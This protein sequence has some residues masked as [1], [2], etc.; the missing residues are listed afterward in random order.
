MT[1]QPPDWWYEPYIGDW[2]E[3]ALITVEQ[4]CKSCKKTTWPPPP[5]VR[6]STCGV[7]GT[8]IFEQECPYGDWWIHRRHPED[9]HDA[10]CATL[11]PSAEE[12][13]DG[14]NPQ[15]DEPV[16]HGRG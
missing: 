3:P 7:C 15:D 9:D 5:D 16:Q 6:T 10:E 13:I 14:T 12:E 1:F 11:T 8:D 2:N 4:L